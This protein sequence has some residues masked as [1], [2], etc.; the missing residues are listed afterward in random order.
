MILDGPLEAH[1]RRAPF[2]NGPDEIAV[3]RLVA[4]DVPESWEHDPRQA[5]PAGHDHTA[6][7]FECDDPLAS[8]QLRRSQPAKQRRNLTGIEQRAHRAVVVPERHHH[9][10]HARVAAATGA[11]TRRCGPEALNGNDSR[12]KTS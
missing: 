12:S 6:V 9:A 3:H 10:F 11:V 8:E 5:T 1:L 7:R 4:T 2:T